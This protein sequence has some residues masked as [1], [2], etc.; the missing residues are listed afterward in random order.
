MV[1]AAD[2][3]TYEDYVDARRA[4]G[5]QVIPRVLW[6]TLKEMIEEDE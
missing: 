5:L 4:E 1:N 2:F 3:P 6:E